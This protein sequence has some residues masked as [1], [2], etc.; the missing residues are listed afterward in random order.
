MAALLAVS[1]LVVIQP[2]VNAAGNPCEAGKY[3]PKSA[4]GA[5]GNEYTSGGVFPR[6]GNIIYRVNKDNDEATVINYDHSFT[7]SLVI[8]ED[9]DITAA[10]ID[11]AGFD[12]AH[13]SCMPFAKSYKVRYLAD[14]SLSASYG[15]VKP[16]LSAI[17]INA[18]I[19]AIGQ[20][21]FGDQCKIQSMVIPDSVTH[22]GE[23]AFWFMDGDK[24]A[25]NNP[26][27]ASTDGITSITLGVNLKLLY[28]Q[29][30]RSNGNL[31]AV[32]FRGQPLIRTAQT[33]P[34]E[35]ESV[36][37]AMGSNIQNECRYIFSYINQMNINVLAGSGSDWTTWASENNCFGA[38]ANTTVTVTDNITTPPVKMSAPVA[39]N[40]TQNTA[41]V[42]FTTQ[43]LDGGS[44]ITSYLVTSVPGGQTAT[45][46]GATGGTVTV[47]GLS[48]ATAYKFNVVAINANG[49][50]STSELSNS[51]T[52]TSLTAPNI[53]L[54]SATESATVGQT[55]S[56]YTISNT[57]GA[58]AT[59]SI[60]PS[61]A[62]GLSFSTATGLI[63]GQPAAVAVSVTYTITATNTAGA[64]TA[65]FAITVVAAPPPS[66]S[67][68][69]IQSPTAP[70]DLTA[71]PSL[72]TA[73]ISWS[74][75]SGVT[76]YR[77]FLDTA[78]TPL[79]IVTGNSTELSGLT[80]N[81][82]Y[83][84]S[85]VAINVAGQSAKSTIG[86]T[87]DNL[88]RISIYFAGDRS[89]IV[90]SQAARLDAF[91]AQIPNLLTA[92]VSVVGSVKKTAGATAAYDRKLA[93]AR[94]ESVFSRL[95]RNGARALKGKIDALPATKSLDSQ[96]RAIVEVVYP[97][98]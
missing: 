35:Y 94:A 4:Q 59:Y 95:A 15:A 54:S 73:L 45:L 70:T 98:S 74:N 47:S 80:K 79:A 93:T 12:S 11:A 76:E 42:A 44:P 55:I 5:P 78:T 43:T 87:T 36:G 1:S 8:P 18:Q 62:N 97:N 52:T 30:I 39:S 38:P 21:A 50:S 37:M 58:A 31:T 77:L 60:S 29:A 61:I 53:A 23:G 51:V 41:D 34:S 72:T 92:Q 48:A 68:P 22:I 28:N 16:V 75:Q 64:D 96:R 71:D 83:L 13:A 25:R 56:A 82:R 26:N 91:V 63:S 69:S 81:T 86:F 20:Y 27:C 24:G 7:G 32:T 19:K 6:V 14:S 33:Y 3:L 90:R 66:S 67:G 9:I 65:T 89:A 88:V 40:P 46:S 2:A 57:G 49:T 10:I 17:T 85:L 84:V